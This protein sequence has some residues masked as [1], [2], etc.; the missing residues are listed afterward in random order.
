MARPPS[1]A[2][3]DLLA[4]Q[5]PHVVEL[6]LATRELIVDEVPEAKEEI[7]DVKY[8]VSIM[9]TYTGN[10]T[11]AFVYIAVY[12]KW[13]NI[14]FIQ[15]ATMPDPYK[16]LKGTGKQM[17]HIRIATLGDLERP[18]V[19]QYIQAAAESAPRV[20]PSAKKASTKGKT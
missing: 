17:R 11:T 4:A 1:A 20:D 16:A 3:L 10:W 8:A 6:A 15:G 14:G 5:D 19:R 13:V 18:Y 7:F 12:T 9:F 2:L